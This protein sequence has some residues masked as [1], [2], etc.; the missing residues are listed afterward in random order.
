MPESVGAALILKRPPTLAKVFW[1]WLKQAP[2]LLW[3]AAY[4]SVMT[5]QKQGWP[6]FSSCAQPGLLSA[7]GH[8]PAWMASRCLADSAGHDSQC[9]AKS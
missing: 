3:A 2:L 1:M 9:G 4:I 8:V 7:M 5:T 6:A